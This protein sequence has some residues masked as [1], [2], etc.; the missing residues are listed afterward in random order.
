MKRDRLAF[1]LSSVFCIFILTFL[2]TIPAFSQEPTPSIF[3]DICIKPGM[4]YEFEKFMKEEVIPAL[5]K[6]EYGEMGAYKIAIFGDGNTYSL[7]SPVEDLAQFDEP[8]PLVKAVGPYAAQA[9]SAKMSKFAKNMKSFIMLPVPD[10]EIPAPEG[11]SAKLGLQIKVTVA[12]GRDKEYVENAKVMKEVLKK[13]KVKGFGAGRVGL[14]GN[15]NQFY[16]FAVFDSFADLQA[17]GPG[18]QKAI[19]ETKM[20]DEKGIIQHVEYA[21]YS[22]VP[23]LSIQAAAQ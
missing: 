3:T 7:V 6:S 12:P 14:G 20:P 18:F 17:F 2:F 4:D 11:Y 22:A 21:M 13:A 5:K 15:P 19:S 1:I 23:E 16:F 9:M 8:H 10:L